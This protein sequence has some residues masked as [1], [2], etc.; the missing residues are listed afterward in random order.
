MKLHVDLR[1][2]LP[3]LLCP[4]LLFH[5]LMQEGVWIGTHDVLVLAAVVT[6][7]RIQVV[8]ARLEHDFTP[9]FAS[10]VALA[11]DQGK[12]SVLLGVDLLLVKFEIQISF[13]TRLNNIWLNTI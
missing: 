1:I 7:L 4:A 8:A 3:L 12:Q 11:L 2:M 6:D 10:P 9:F 5:D 13:R